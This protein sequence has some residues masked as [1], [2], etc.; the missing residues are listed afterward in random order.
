MHGQKYGYRISLTA[1]FLVWSLAIILVFGVTASVLFWKINSMVEES[2]TIVQTHYFVVEKS[3]SLINNLLSVTEY[4]KRYEILEKLEDR[5]RFLEELRRFQQDLKHYLGLAAVQASFQNLGIDIPQSI[6]SG[7]PAGG[8]ALDDDTADQWLEFFSA[9]RDD[10]RVRMAQRL[11]DLEQKGNEAF[12]AGLLGLGLCSVIVVA[13]SVVL[14]VRMSTSTRELKKGLQRVGHG[15]Q[16]E[17]VR[18]VSHDELGDLSVMFNDMIQRLKKEEEKRSDFISMLSHEIRT[19]LTSIRESLSLIQ[20]QVFGPVTEKQAHFL[21]VSS[22]EVERLSSF[23]NRLLIASSMD[24]QGLVLERKVHSIKDLIQ[25]GIERVQP[26]AHAKGIEIRVEDHT[27]NADVFADRD[28]LQQVMVNLIGNAVKFSPEAG[29]V[30]VLIV[31]SQNDE[32]V[33]VTVKDQ[34]PGIPEDDRPYVFDR[35]YRGKSVRTKVDGSGLGLN[36]TRRIIA[37]HGGDVWF[38]SGSLE[39]TAFSFELPVGG[40]A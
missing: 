12:Q 33:I 20:E 24:E 2:S 19:P 30:Q 35:F 39:G 34:G 17:P 26:T 7:H 11:Q 15:E 10:Q 29:I 21:H 1:K 38:E 31:F 23:L 28:H 27:G 3:E 16:L 13:G 8:G 37:A 6:Q 22:Q 40:E 9:V 36:I 14:I 25:G 5:F 18:V 4:K 32:K